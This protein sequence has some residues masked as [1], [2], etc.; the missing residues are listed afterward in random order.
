VQVIDLA[1]RQYEG[2][3]DPQVTPSIWQ[4]CGGYNHLVH[5]HIGCSQQSRVRASYAHSANHSFRLI[6]E[7]Q[8][9]AEGSPM[10]VFSNSHKPTE[11][12]VAA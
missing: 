5:G 2:G 8:C 4:A 6:T 9:G 1:R 3:R 12:V 10:V 7:P 11:G